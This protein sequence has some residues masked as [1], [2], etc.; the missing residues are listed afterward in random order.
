MA[1]RAYH[2]R[3]V[4]YLSEVFADKR[5]DRDVLAQLYE[6]QRPS[7]H[8]HRLPPAHLGVER[9]AQVVLKDLRLVENPSVMLILANVKPT[10]AAGFRT[11]WS[12]AT[13]NRISRAGKR[14]A[15]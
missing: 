2:L 14:S 4:V 8:I 12:P 7:R 3:N 11:G 13:T 1:D 5:G 9:A 15:S 6:L 10:Y